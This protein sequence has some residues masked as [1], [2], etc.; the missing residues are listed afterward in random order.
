MQRIATQHAN[1]TRIDWQDAKLEPND[2]PPNFITD[3]LDNT[4][5]D[6]WS[7]E[8]ERSDS[9][10]HIGFA[11]FSLVDRNPSSLLVLFSNTIVPS[12]PSQDP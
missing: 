10:T 8:M 5:S 12:R 2:F 6:E 11:H 9:E 4:R 3:Q 1:A 7:H